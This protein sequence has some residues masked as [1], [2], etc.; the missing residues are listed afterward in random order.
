MAS[1][2]LTGFRAFPGVS[3]NPT[4]ALISHI[5]GQPHLLPPGTRL[6]LLDVDYRS[7]GPAIDGLLADSPAAIVLTGY[8][9]LAEGVTLEMQAS[10]MCA[11]DKPD[12]GGFVAQPAQGPALRTGI[13]LARLQPLVERHAPCRISRDAGQYLCNFSYRH[14]LAR[15]MERGL[16]T[17]VLFV[18][19]PALSGT[20]LAEQSAASLPMD[21]MVAALAG[22][23][24]ALTDHSPPE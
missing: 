18:H 3:E 8:S 24:H 4:E 23:I 20:P 5:A 15:V 12:A 22:I 9:P 17:Q 1:A 2:V 7:V 16:P 19:L 13:D 10:A 14:S 21:A 11:A 6:A